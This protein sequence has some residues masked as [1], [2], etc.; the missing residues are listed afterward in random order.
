MSSARLSPLDLFAIPS[1]NTTYMEKS[2]YE[3]SVI[4]GK[5]KRTKFNAHLH[6]H[7]YCHSPPLRPSLGVTMVLRRGA[8]RKA[9]MFSQPLIDQVSDKDSSSAQLPLPPSVPETGIFLS[10][11]FLSNIHVLRCHESMQT[12]YQSRL[13]AWGWKIAVALVC[14]LSQTPAYQKLQSSFITSS[15]TKT[16]TSSWTCNKNLRP[17]QLRL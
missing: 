16:S 15:L 11:A 2:N 10:L 3:R 7:P 5:R 6:S 1:I 4:K 17:S 14:P 13:D 9:H 8:C 12:V